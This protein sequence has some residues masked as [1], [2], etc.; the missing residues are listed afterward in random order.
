MVPCV[1]R[2]SLSRGDGSTAVVLHG[3]ASRVQVSSQKNVCALAPCLVSTDAG[4]RR[5]CSSVL[6]SVVVVAARMIPLTHMWR[7]R[8]LAQ[9]V[10]FVSV[11]N[12]T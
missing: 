3:Y 9:R 4:V 7:R 5:G 8:F 1:R 11:A 10:E 2:V 6:C 12:G